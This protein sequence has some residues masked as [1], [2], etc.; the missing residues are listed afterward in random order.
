MSR[1]GVTAGSSTPSQITRAVIAR[2][3]AWQLETHV[4]A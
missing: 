2:L 1:V 3:E 4:R